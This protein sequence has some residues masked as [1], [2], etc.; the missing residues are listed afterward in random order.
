MKIRGMLV[1]GWERKAKRPICFQAFTNET[2]VIWD[3]KVALS[4]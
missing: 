2:P 4:R 1:Q 3:I